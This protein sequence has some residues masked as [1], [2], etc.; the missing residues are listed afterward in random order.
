MGRPMAKVEAAVKAAWKT[1]DDERSHATELTQKLVPNSFAA[2]I[3]T[4]TCGPTGDGF[5]ARDEHVEI[6][7]LEETT[8]TV[9][10]AII[11]WRKIQ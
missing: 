2:G 11:D 5:D 10:A 9:A 7:S 3:G 6:A 1:I 8:T 4:V